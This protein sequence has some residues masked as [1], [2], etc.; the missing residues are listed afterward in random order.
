MFRT[1]LHTVFVLLALLT[2]S[3][4]GQQKTSSSSF[5]KPTEECYAD[6]I[7]QQF[8]VRFTNGESVV[9]RAQSEKAFLDGYMTENLDRIEFAEPDY[10]VKAMPAS[11]EVRAASG[12]MNN[13]GMAKIGADTFW[14]QNIRGAGVSV[15]VIDTGMDVQHPQLASRVLINTNEI[16]GNG[17]DDDG[18]GKVD[19]YYGWNY[20][21]DK[22]TGR[23]TPLTGDNQYHGTHVSGVV[24]AHHTD[25]TAGPQ[26]YVQGAAPEAKILPLAFLDENGDGAMSAAV[27]AINY[28]VE[29]GVRVINA[30]WG[31]K[32]CSRTL[33]DTIATL[34]AKNVL[35]IAASGNEGWNID[36]TKVYPA[37]LNFPALFTV[38]ATGE[39]DLMSEFSNYGT[40]SVHIFAPGTQIISTFPNGQAANLSGTSMAAPFVTGAM[41]LLLSAAPTAT[42]TQLR[43]AIYNTAFKNSNYMN[44]SM[45]RMDVRQ[46]RTELLRILSQ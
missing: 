36:R 38:G 16:N 45:G 39:F 1:P 10:M 18:N 4:C 8:L 3:A 41:A 2:L 26:N 31:G 46:A 23:E 19:D 27:R 22:N 30:S 33:R 28:A 17:I 42:N 25:T 37:S 24:A 43:Q 15:A 34:D 12:T 29:R 5:E 13:W 40:K 32:Y 7:P 11:S 9:V 6:V 35:F 44:A 20:V 14:Q 21:P